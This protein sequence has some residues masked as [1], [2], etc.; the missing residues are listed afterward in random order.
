LLKV[1][2]EVALIA[3][4]VVAGGGAGDAERARELTLVT[5]LQVALWKEAIASL[6]AGVDDRRRSDFMVRFAA[7]QIFLGQFDDA[8]D[9]LE[10]ALALREALVTETLTRENVFDIVGHTSG[11]G[12]TLAYCR[13]KLGQP[14][15]GLEQL[16]RAQAAELRRMLNSEHVAALDAEHRAAFLTAQDRLR[17][18]QYE[19]SRDAFAA[20][21][22]RSG[23]EI[24]ADIRVAQA[25]LRAALGDD[26]AQD[27]VEPAL[28]A[29]DIL[30]LAPR[31]GVVIVPLVTFAGGAAYII[32]GGISEITKDNVVELP[33]LSGRTVEDRLMKWRRGYQSMKARAD[34]GDPEPWRRFEP[35]IEDTLGWLW[36]AVMQP[37]LE[38][39]RKAGCGSA[40]Q[41]GEIIILATGGL[42]NLPVH[43]AWNRAVNMYLLDDHVVT[44]APSFYALRACRRR[45]QAY[46]P[47][48]NGFVGVFDPQQGSPHANL[49]LSATFEWPQLRRAFQ[50]HCARARELIGSAATA[51]NLR[52]ES[53]QSDYLHLSCHNEFD[54][55][56]P[57]RS[58]VV[59]AGG[60]VMDLRQI[61]GELRLEGCR[62][63]SIAACETAITAAGKLA[64]EQFGLPAAFIQAG[65]PVVVATLWPVMDWSTAVIMARMYDLLLADHSGPAAALRQAMLEFRD[66]RLPPAMLEDVKAIGVDLD[67]RL[68]FFWAPF[69]TIGE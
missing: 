11:V 43:A 26:V 25:A 50:L 4:A 64:S 39:A 54:W 66:G 24:A 2:Q 48:G 22:Q 59:L 9:L 16:E 65:A 42:S 20:G 32:P 40:L 44:S 52:Q 58:G 6:P 57:E 38:G 12:E 47:S 17:R 67:H 21:A 33:E 55:L 1:L 29:R 49:E 14:E 60:E 7:W 15:L 36:D 45:A 8:A 62:L 23:A 31:N 41:G 34:L 69:V 27:G 61:A 68:P 46:V 37:V 51:A 53:R 18:L 35:V 63:V 5:E 3:P 30:A 10:N 28:S 56:R 13:I 19:F